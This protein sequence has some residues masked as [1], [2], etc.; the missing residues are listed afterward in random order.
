MIRSC[1]THTTES[2][3]YPGRFNSYEDRS[4]SVY[5]SII[6]EGKRQM[7]LEP[8]S[9]AILGQR[10]VPTHHHYF[11]ATAAALSCLIHTSTSIAAED[12]CQ[13]P[14]RPTLSGVLSSDLEVTIA[15]NKVEVFLGASVQYLK[16]L[17][18]FAQENVDKLTRQEI[19]SPKDR[20]QAH[21]AF[22][23][24]IPTGWNQRYSAYHA[25]Q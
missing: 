15:Y 14:D 20:Y 4:S 12:E 23:R 7:S 21:I 13:R 24:N 22:M 3:E 1:L 8:K 11:F 17:S 25:R 6:K 2:P 10:P 5:S 16:C 9:R 18:N 19:A